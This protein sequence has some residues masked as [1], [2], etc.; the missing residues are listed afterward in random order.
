MSAH[1]PKGPNRC[2]HPC[3]TSCGGLW[4]DASAG[5]RDG[6]THRRFTVK[7]PGQLHIEHGFHGT[8]MAARLMLACSLRTTLS[9]ET[10]GVQADGVATTRVWR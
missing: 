10:P 1:R 4:H 7:L 6:S 2:Y 5:C 8:L 3:T 9:P